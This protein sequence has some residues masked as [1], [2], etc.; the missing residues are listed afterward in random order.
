MTPLKNLALAVITATSVAYSAPLAS[1]QDLFF[2][3]LS[4]ANEVP[5]NGSPATGRAW[6][7][8]DRVSR[9]LWYCVDTAGLV[10]TAAHIH[11][12]PVG[13]NGAVIFPLAGGPTIYGG[14]TGALTDAQIQNLYNEQYY[15]NVHTAA[16]PGGEIRGQLTKAFARTTIGTLSGLQEVPPTP[17]A[18]T[19]TARVVLHEP[20][21]RITYEVKVSGLFGPPTAAHIHQAAAGVNGPVIV[22]LAGTIIGAGAE[23]CGTAVLTAAQVAALLANGCYVNVHTAAFAGGEVRAQ[24]IVQKEEFTCVNVG[25]EETPPNVSPNTGLGIFTFDPVTS[26][27]AYSQTWTGLGGTA[28]HVHTAVPTLAGGILY[29]LAGPANGPWAG[30]SPALAAAAVN[31][32]FETR[33]YSNVHSAAFPAGEVRD[34]L[35]QNPNIFG[36]PSLTTAG[37]VSRTLRIGASG[38]AIL[39]SSWTCKVFDALPGA[40]VSLA[41]AEDLAGMPLDIGPFGVSPPCAV[42]WVNALTGYPGGADAQGCAQQTFSVPPLAVFLGQDFFFQWVS[43]EAGLIVWSNALQVVVH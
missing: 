20:E 31:D 35:R 13:V 28:A 43:I 25:S 17:S 16:L 7:N 10:G 22:T 30:A 36:F 11:Q 18:G 1:S 4:G 26:M 32:L 37:S 21:H 5:P 39:G 38:P 9:R 2:A 19:G 40:F 3:T 42:L 15:V 34:Q 14:V 27:V 23:Y 29:G 33:H 41:Y 12:A 24:L 8:F 6:V